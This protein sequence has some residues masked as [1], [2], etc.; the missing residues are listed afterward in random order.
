LRGAKATKK[1]RATSQNWI[2][3]LALA[4]TRIPAT[5]LR[6]NFAMYGGRRRKT[7][8]A[9]YLKFLAVGV[10]FASPSLRLKYLGA[11]D[12]DARHKAGHNE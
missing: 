5:R 7:A 1:S 8:A 12:V 9:T 11:K 4:M 6:P 10:G 2:A 3:S